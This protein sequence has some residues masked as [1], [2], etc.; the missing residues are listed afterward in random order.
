MEVSSQHCIG[1]DVVLEIKPF[2]FYH[3]TEERHL[4]PTHMLLCWI[5][6]GRIQEGFIFRRFMAS[7]RISAENKPL[8]SWPA[9]PVRNIV[10][11]IYRAK[12]YFQSVFDTI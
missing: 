4:D 1:A 9:R 2:H 5:R 3:N 6:E 7:D 10:L 8:V 12:I 11:L